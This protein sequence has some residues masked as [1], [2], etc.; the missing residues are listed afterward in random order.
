MILNYGLM[1]VLSFGSLGLNSCKRY[2]EPTL[3]AF[4]NINLHL[5]KFSL[6]KEIKEKDKDGKEVLK[7]DKS[8][9]SAF[10]SIQNVKEEGLIANVKALPYGTELK[11]VRFDIQPVME[12]TKIEVSLDNGTTFEE[13]KKGD[14]KTYTLS[15]PNNELKV[16][17]TLVEPTT[18][19]VAYAYTYKVQVK[20]YKFDPETI[21]WSKLAT[22]TSDVLGA[23][24]Q[25]ASYQ[26]SADKMMLMNVDETAQSNKFYK[27][28][29]ETKA[30]DEETYPALPNSEYIKELQHYKSIVFV[31]SSAK[32]LYQL[33]ETNT[34][35]ALDQ[36]AEALLGV[37]APRKEGA[38]ASLA[39]I[40]KANGASHFANYDVATKKLEQGTAVGDDFP[41]TKYR[42]LSTYAPEVGAGLWLLGADGVVYSTTN[43]TAWAKSMADKAVDALT[44]KSFAF[45][46]NGDLLYRFVTDTQGLT[47]Y[48]KENVQ[49]PWKKN[50]T[51]ALTPA[52][53]ETFDAGSF[54]ETNIALWVEGQT[55]F[56]YKG[57]DNPT[58]YKGELKKNAV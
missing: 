1:A 27:L 5:A 30:F 43:G 28:N 25:F 42:T 26:P 41:Q 38:E 35:K 49:S 44:V 12:S 3:Q 50:G 18:G 14:K 22:P 32:K 2:K 52:E 29:T 34:W 9:G 51:V 4:Q 39:L 17:L 10:F 19:E 40:V 11:D 57:G 53:G 7:M 8:I 45:V 36:E 56:L 24:G 47:L 6:S 58:L 31:L 13:W 37:F 48:T 46:S 20:V 23:S 21:H 33:T 15:A 16:R 54:A 55:F